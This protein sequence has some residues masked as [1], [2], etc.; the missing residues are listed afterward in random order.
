MNHCLESLKKGSEEE[1]YPQQKHERVF[2]CVSQL[3]HSYWAAALSQVPV[4]LRA[5]EWR[6]VEQE[7]N[8]HWCIT[9]TV[10]VTATWRNLVMQ[11]LCVS[12]SCCLQQFVAGVLHL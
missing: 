3:T 8:V 6:S 4:H 9:I 2:S 11:E 10:C 12:V 7:G 1:S 5:V